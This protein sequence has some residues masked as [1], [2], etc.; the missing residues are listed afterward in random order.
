[1]ASKIQLRRDTAANWTS[2]N[3]VLSNGEPG[4]ETDTRRIKYGDG[5]TAW[6]SLQYAGTSGNVNYADSAGTVTANAQPNITSVG[7]LTALTV[8][9]NVAADKFIGDG[10]LLT[11][12]VPTY[13]NSNVANYLPNYTGALS[14]STAN[15]TG[16]VILSNIASATS[17]TSG[18]LRVAG[19]MGVQGNVYAGEVHVSNIIYSGSFADQAD[20]LNSTTNPV[21]IGFKGGQNYVQGVVKNSLGTGSADWTAFND[22]GNDTN[23]WI[24]QGIAG[25]TFN[26]ANYTITGPGDGYLFNKGLVGFGG[27]LVLATGQTGG[28]NDIVFATGGFLTTNEFG[29]IQCQNNTFKLTRDNASITFT[30]NT[31]QNTAWTG[32]VATGNVTG[33][34]NISTV[35][36]DGSSSN[37]LYG[38]GLFASVSA[39]SY[40][41]ANVADYLPTYTG[42]V[43]TAN[44]TFVANSKIDSIANSSG[45]NSGYSTMQLIPDSSLTENDQ[46]LIIDPT[47]PSHIHIRAGG[48]QDDS[49]AE[50]YLGGEANY[51][52][53]VDGSGVRIQNQTRNDTTYSYS[54]PGTFTTGTWYEDTGTYYVQY[55]T[56]DLELESVTFEFNNDSENTLL[57]YYN[58]GADSATLT[59]AGSIS[60]LGGGVYRVSVNE[61]PPASPTAL[62]AFEYTIWTDRTNSVEL[63]SNDF[64][65]SVTDDIRI[66]GRDTFSLRNESPNSPITIRTDY[67]G[68]DHA[69][70]FD[71]DGDLFLP[72]SGELV[73]SSG[74]EAGRIIPMVSDGV[75]LQI[76]AEL[77]FEIKVNDGEGGSNTWSFAGNDI[78]FPDG[79]LQS[80]A[81]APVTGSWTLAPGINTVSFTVDWN[82]TYTMWVRGNIPNGIAVWNATVTVTNSNVPVVGTQ[83]GWYYVDG[84]ALV[85]TAIP[86]QIVGTA[87]GISTAAPAVG[88]T[89]NTFVFSITNNTAE[90]Q[91]VY[92]GYTKL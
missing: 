83:Y 56:A 45:D 64:T 43:N 68:A 14:G 61:A 21:F 18:A 40:G 58:A 29:R 24:S 71:P 20:I 42:V 80:T 66:T 50:L 7:A 22:I 4:Y 27:N 15:L 19:G 57:V 90:A 12:L 78:A 63:S 79:T 54:D 84:G 13:G 48:T 89:S 73:F 65:V 41:N 33:L 9:G 3:P 30:D 60:N 25:S 86:D 59:S 88:T 53:V 16:T 8:T 39:G 52:R 62:S 36:L 91:T 5:V 10:G 28:C 55:T 69:W 37:V 46:Y 31:V 17:L 76:Q 1:M 35:N 81:Y 26:D 47:V 49:Q 44:I 11:N 38:N 72:N 2:V 32:S 74:G 34:G 6:N 92:Y 85:L 77:D 75:G 51:V 87:G 82:Y 23:G 67:D 70:E